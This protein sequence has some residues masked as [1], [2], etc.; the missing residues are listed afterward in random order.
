MFSF[1]R[2]S[3]DKV[4]SDLTKKVEQLYVLEKQHLAGAEA[5][6]ALVVASLENK[7]KALDASAK[8]SRIGRK[9]QE[10]VS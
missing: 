8:A 5:H 4:V 9:I 6:A 10:L 7:A 1:L 3:V 2:N